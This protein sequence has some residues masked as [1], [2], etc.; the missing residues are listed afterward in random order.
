MKFLNFVFNLTVFE[1]NTHYRNL[2]LIFNN[3][4][5]IVHLFLYS[6]TQLEDSLTQ[7]KH[8]AECGF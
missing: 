5:T 1:H 3:M 4:F 8:V 6:C 2:D 7:P